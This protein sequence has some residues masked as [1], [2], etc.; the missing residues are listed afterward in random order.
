MSWQDHAACK[1]MDNELFFSERGDTLGVELGKQVCAEC[2]VKVQCLE[3]AIENREKYG[4]WGGK[5]E[6]QRREIRR[7]RHMTERAAS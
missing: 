6:R 2:P 5:S 3:Y 7:R 1:G 4:I